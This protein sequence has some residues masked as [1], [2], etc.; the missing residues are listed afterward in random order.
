[1]P[2]IYPSKNTENCKICSKK[3]IATMITFKGNAGVTVAATMI[4]AK[5]AAISVVVTGGIGGVHR[6]D[7]KSWDVSAD[8]TELGKYSTLTPPEI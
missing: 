2:P 4:I 8:L 6:G 1:M 5:M 7:D 3:D